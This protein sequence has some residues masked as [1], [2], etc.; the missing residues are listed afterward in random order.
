MARDLATKLGYQK[1][2]DPPFNS[3]GQP[4]F[5]NGNRYITPD[6]DQHNGG[7]WKMF[8]RLGNRLGTYDQTLENRI[9]K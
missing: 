5:K 9:G 3:H 2:K 8:D 6:V 4:V 7:F 1:I